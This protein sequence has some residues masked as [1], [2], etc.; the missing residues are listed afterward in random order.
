[1]AAGVASSDTA[2]ASIAVGDKFDA[3]TQTW[4][5]VSPNLGGI[6]PEF[7]S[8]HGQAWSPVAAR[9]AASPSAA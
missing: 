9:R 7:Q 6:C 1:M 4:T 2:R 5:D 3:T 8:V